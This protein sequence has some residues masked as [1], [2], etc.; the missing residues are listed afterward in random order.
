MSL[1]Y[2]AIGRGAAGLPGKMRTNSRPS[3]A[4]LDEYVWAETGRY[5]KGWTRRAASSKGTPSFMA[6]K[7]RAR[8]GKVNFPFFQIPATQKNG[9]DHGIWS[10]YLRRAEPQ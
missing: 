8:W 10:D 5:A 6:D 2:R 9:E 3:V 4:A 1:L 7:I